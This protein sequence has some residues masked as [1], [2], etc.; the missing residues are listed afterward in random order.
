MSSHENGEP[1]ELLYWFSKNG[2]R[3]SKEDMNVSFGENNKICGKCHLT[4][5]RSKEYTA[6]A[7]IISNGPFFAWQKS[8]HNPGA[9]GE[10]IIPSFE[11]RNLSQFWVFQWKESG[12]KAKEQPM[13][14]T[15][16]NGLNL[17]YN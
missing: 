3:R 1:I 5:D 15:Q 12:I 14:M 10:K 16:A 11:D 17:V 4:V 2:I 8:G 6:D 13:L 7:I 9:P